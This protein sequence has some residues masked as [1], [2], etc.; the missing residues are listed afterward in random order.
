MSHKRIV[1]GMYP[2][3]G[4][5]ARTVTFRP[6][7]RS[8]TTIRRVAPKSVGYREGEVRRDEEGQMTLDFRRALITEIPSFAEQFGQA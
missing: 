1:N 8:G 4:M 6:E 5:G 3:N 2:K 7:S